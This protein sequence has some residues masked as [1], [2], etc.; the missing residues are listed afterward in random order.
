MMEKL[1]SNI[2]H[3]QRAQRQF[4]YS[5]FQWILKRSNSA[6]NHNIKVPYL[7]THCHVTPMKSYVQ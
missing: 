5:V 7:R 2:L 1:C 6:P 3:T 4:Y